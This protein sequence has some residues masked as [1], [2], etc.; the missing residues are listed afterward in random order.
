MKPFKTKTVYICSM[1]TTNKTRNG[2][3]RGIKIVFLAILLQS[4]V[5]GISILL[6]ANDLY[7][8]NIENDASAAQTTTLNKVNHPSNENQAHYVPADS[9]DDSGT[10]ETAE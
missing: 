1:K 7:P 5:L 8:S 3:A 4:F 2:I 6:R 10:D 9:Q